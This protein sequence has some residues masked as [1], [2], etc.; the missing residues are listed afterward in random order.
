[1]RSSEGMVVFLKLKKSKDFLPKQDFRGVGVDLV[2]VRRPAPRESDGL[3][4]DL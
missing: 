4:T 1:M 2:W 3:N